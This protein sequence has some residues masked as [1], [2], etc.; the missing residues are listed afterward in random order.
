MVAVTDSPAVRRSGTAPA[1]RRR[2][3]MTRRSV[4]AIVM[5]LP[6]VLSFALFSWWPIVQTVLMSFQSTNFI[7]SEFVGLANFRKVLADP[8]LT[9]AVGNTVQFTLWSVLIGFPVPLLL[10]VVIAEL[11]R[12]RQVASVLAYLP[13]II[14]PVVAVLLWKTLY[15]PSPTGALNTI[16]AAFGIG[17]LAWLN[18]PNLVIPAIIVEMTW[19]TFGTAT[20]IYVATLMTIRTDLY[21]AA[22][23]D[24][25]GILRR[26]WHVTLPQMRPIILMMLLLQLIGVFQ[27]FTEPYIMT[28]GGPVNRSVTIMMLIY[29]YAFQYADYGAATALSFMLAIVLGAFSAVYLRLTRRWSSS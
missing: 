15:D 16:L 18:D 11:R 13:V 2:R 5:A 14:P 7:E 28:G 26:V 24:G 20:I 10:A 23:S 27:T 19:A 6:L 22:E 25:A 8:L 29:R 9:T 12:S 21:E 17:P 1:G 3:R 4:T